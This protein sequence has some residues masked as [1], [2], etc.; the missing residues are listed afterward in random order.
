MNTN[1]NI[2]RAECLS[3]RSSE[4]A[5]SNRNLRISGHLLSPLSSIQFLANSAAISHTLRLKLTEIFFC[6]TNRISLLISS[7]T[8]G[9]IFV[10]ISEKLLKIS[11][12]KRT[13]ANC[14]ICSIWTRVTNSGEKWRIDFHLFI[15]GLVDQRL[16]QVLSPFRRTD[17]VV[18]LLRP[19]NTN[20]NKCISMST[21]QRSDDSGRQSIPQPLTEIR[22]LCST[23]WIR[24]DWIRWP[25]GDH[26]LDN[27]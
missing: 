13:A 25:F 20:V 24:S 16:H 12:R 15:F 19:N 7:K 26:C 18:Q 27:T 22:C 14:R 1:A 11:R 21:D 10:A 9:A 8:F 23:D 5:E 3:W 2:R 4:L 6:R 17:S